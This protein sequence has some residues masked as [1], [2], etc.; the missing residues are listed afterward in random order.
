MENSDRAF[1]NYRPNGNSAPLYG[2]RS[3][4]RPII[5]L[6]GVTRVFKRGRQQVDVL[7]NVSMTINRGEFVAITGASGS[8]KSTLLQLIGGLDEPT[9]GEVIIDDTDINTL[10]DGKLSEFRNKTIGFIFQ[11]FY[12]QPF[13][14]LSNNTEL[15]AMFAH[16][17]RKERR[18]KAQDLLAK[19]NLTER[20]EH[21]PKEL[22]GGQMQRA[23]VARALLNEPKILLADEPTGNLDS[24][25]SREMIDLFHKIRRERGTTI[26]I[27]T[28]DQEIANG[29]D[30]EI[31]LSDGVVI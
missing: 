10:P 6:N 28:H 11:F 13:L 16:R 9:S 29:A 24:E 8:G 31:K 15:P 3:T 12:L 22:S 4:T 20:S 30:R 18:P 27:V 25:N 2:A 7:K 14:K 19:V 23:A 21:Y 5:V 17:K 26:V 1:A